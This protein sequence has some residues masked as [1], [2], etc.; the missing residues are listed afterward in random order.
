M[1]IP[2]TREEFIE[3]CLRALGKPVVQIN[4]DDDQVEDRVS[5]AIYMYQQYH[6]DAVIQTYMSH[7]VTASTL[8][9]ASPYT[10]TFQNNEILVGQTSNTRGQ[11][12]ATGNAT[13]IQFFTMTTTGDSVSSSDEYSD[14]SR[15]SFADGEVVTGLSSG[16][17]GTIATSNS[18]FTA[19][20]RGDM[21]NRWFPI[22]DD[23]IAVTK[24]FPPYDSRLSA[25]I[26]FDPQ[27]QFNI[28]LMSNFTANSIVPYVVGRQYQQLLNDTFRGR[29]GIRFSRHTN[30]LYVDVNWY[31]TFSPGQHVVLEGYRTINPDTFADVWSDRWLQRYTIALLKQQW[32]INLSK[33]TGIAMPGGV[34][35]DGRAMLADA[36]QEVR[37]LE[38]ELKNVYQAP[39]MFIVG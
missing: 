14:T 31:T 37:E 22:A 5:E 21:D 26:L 23:V 16:A 15:P 25:D 33:Y 13:S 3:Y 7:T 2:T 12:Y 39:P 11:F 35:L 10:G 18:S 8:H 20:V 36:K 29:P 24:V 6:Y 34:Q 9:F 1:P 4:V 32:G 30:R 28:S 19:V 17:T 27:S 38:D